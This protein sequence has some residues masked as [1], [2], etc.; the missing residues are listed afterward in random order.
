MCS[1]QPHP[2]SF[3]LLPALFL[4]L[5]SCKSIDQENTTISANDESQLGYD[6]FYL[7]NCAVCHGDNLQGASQGPP[8]VGTLKHGDSLQSLIKSISEGYIEQGMPGWSNTLSRAEIKSAAMYIA[9]TR[10]NFSYYDFNVDKKLQIPPGRITTEL[11]GFHYKTIAQNLDQLPY[12]IEPLA[13]GKILVTEKM[14]GLRIID[15]HGNK[16]T[17]IKGT[18]SVFDDSVTMGPQLE[19]GLGWLFEVVA[20]PNYKE[21]QWVYLSYT[22][23]CDN[24]GQNDKEEQVPVSMLKVIRGRIDNNQWVDE[25]V[26]WKVETDLYTNNSDIITGARMT[27]DNKGHLFFSIGAKGN[28]EYTGVQDLRKPWGK[29]HRINDDGTIPEDNPFNDTPGAIKSIWSIGHRSPQGLEY[30][31][32]TEELWGTEMGPRGGDEINRILPGRNYGWPL[33]SLGMNYDGTPVEYGKTLGIPF[34][35]RDIEQPIVDL[36]P[37][38]AIS[39]FIFYTG[40]MFPGW[41]NQMLVGSLKAS[42][43]FR[44]KFQDALLIDRETIINQ[45]A[46]VRDIEQGPQG[47]IY[48]LLEHKSGG[49]ILQVIPD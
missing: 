25:Q 6:T 22:D 48:L 32:N 13:N 26:I 47:E 3:F 7:D 35:I 29:I 19:Y 38:P 1:K 9:E 24:C 36:T 31:F 34:N 16:S 41:K 30:N 21:N 46:R 39:S 14:R 37:S 18:P 11:H 20:H 12:S 17:L 8:L 43:V 2:L 44:M 15:S 23:R 40:N 4:A 45:L 27:F 33:Y 49:Q 5:A 42:A 28:D 10:E